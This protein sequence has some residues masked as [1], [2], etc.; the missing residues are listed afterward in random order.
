MNFNLNFVLCFKL[1]LSDLTKYLKVKE[2][3]NLFR[4]KKI[5]TNSQI[6]SRVEAREI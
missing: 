1:L 6:K 3:K 4:K 5:T 2:T